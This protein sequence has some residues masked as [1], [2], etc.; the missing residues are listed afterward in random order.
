[1]QVVTAQDVPDFILEIARRAAE[2]TGA[3]AVYL[4]GSHARGEARA[5]SDVDLLIMV[6]DLANLRDTNIALNELLNLIH[7]RLPDK[8]RE[9]LAGDLLV[10]VGFKQPYP[11]EFED[12]NA[13]EAIAMLEAD[14]LIPAYALGLLPIQETP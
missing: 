10:E 1:M 4:F 14:R 13:E 8:A 12:A 3:R 5:D 9:R 11:G 2:A 6:D 7:S